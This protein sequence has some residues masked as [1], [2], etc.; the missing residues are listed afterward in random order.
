MG[1][2][3]SLTH[4]TGDYLFYEKLTSCSNIFIIRL[5]DK[6]SVGYYSMKQI[7]V[8]TSAYGFMF[9][10]CTCVFWNTL[11]YLGVTILHK[12]TYLDMILFFGSSIYPH[13]NI[14]KLNTVLYLY[15]VYKAISY[16]MVAFYYT[17]GG[18]GT[19]TISYQS[20]G[21]T[22]IFRNKLSHCYSAWGNYGLVLFGVRTRWWSIKMG[23]T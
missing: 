12:I 2:R 4:Y 11:Q 20:S 23:V 13:A 22:V 6:T 14:C 5:F 21:A 3:V 1:K 10:P 7:P 17:F 9:P 19:H 8:N 15:I 16:N 18:W